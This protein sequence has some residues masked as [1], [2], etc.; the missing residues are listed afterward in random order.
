MGSAAIAVVG[1]TVAGLALALLLNKRNVRGSKLW[2]A[3]P[4]LA[5][6]IPGFISM[7]ATRW[8]LPMLHG[9][10]TSAPRR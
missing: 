5:Y 10:A 2:R 9:G 8:R 1:K 3:F 6:A 7:P 4:I